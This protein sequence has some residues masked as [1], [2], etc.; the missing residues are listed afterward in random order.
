M[1]VD[2]KLFYFSLLHM[3]QMGG[4]SWTYSEA[5]IF[6]KAVQDI[7]WSKWKEIAASE[8]LPACRTRTA[9]CTYAK[10]L[11]ANDPTRYE[12]L[13]RLS[14]TSAKGYTSSS[15]RPHP[16]VYFQKLSGAYQVQQPTG[17]V[18]GNYPN[19]S[20][21]IVVADAVLQVLPQK[22]KSDVSDEYRKEARTVAKR[23]ARAYEEAPENQQE[24]AEARGQLNDEYTICGNKK[25]YCASGGKDCECLFWFDH[26]NVFDCSKCALKRLHHKIYDG[27]NFYVDDNGEIQEGVGWVH[28]DGQLH[29]DWRNR[30]CEEKKGTVEAEVAIQRQ[31]EVVQRKAV[32]FK[33]AYSDEE[34]RRSI[35]DYQQ[36]LYK[37]KATLAKDGSI[38]FDKNS[39][40]TFEEPLPADELIESFLGPIMAQYP[41]HV[42]LLYVFKA[43]CAVSV[44]NGTF[45]FTI[46]DKEDEAAFTA[47]SRTNHVLT[48]NGSHFLR[49]E[50]SRIGPDNQA[51]GGGFPITSTYNVLSTEL[52]A[53]DH[54]VKLVKALKKK[55]EAL[56]KNVEDNV[57]DGLA[58][59]VLNEKGGGGGN[60]TSNVGAVGITALV[61]KRSDFGFNAEKT[62]QGHL[63]ELLQQVPGSKAIR[64]NEKKHAMLNYIKDRDD[65]YNAKKKVA[66]K[67]AATA[68]ARKG[69]AST[70]T[71]TAKAPAAT[72]TAATS[73]STA[74]ASA[75]TSTAKAAT[76]GT[77]TA[78]A[79]TSTAQKRSVLSPTS[80]NV[81]KQKT[82]EKKKMKQRTLFNSWK[83]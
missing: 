76:A 10:T 63:Q 23:A 46:K 11:K 83:K 35:C 20:Q 7:G 56:K 25:Y 49:K 1:S 19:K 41:E 33:S 82:G 27:V 36:L 62:N 68:K 69:Y 72:S 64:M 78:K 30:V 6:D 18:I 55:V 54:E 32:A 4:T 81:K 17:T 67:E 28:R 2:L 9:I 71:S 74:K 26:G 24:L 52:K 47:P 79:A 80:N 75:A 77:S 43:S 53:L 39:D 58:L 42:I 31:L 3:L 45:V 12:R 13:I 34:T 60:H 21:A 40:Y 59:C 57:T 51:H 73:T 44:Q 15:M 66:A 37:K 38:A 65:A 16:L 8:R 5:K 14:P 61:T 29:P 50:L 48:K 22:D 70:A